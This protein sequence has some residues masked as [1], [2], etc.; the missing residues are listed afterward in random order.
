MVEEGVYA[1][2]PTAI[3]N[4]L[5]GHTVTSQNEV[6]ASHTSHGSPQRHGGSQPRLEMIYVHS[7]GSR[8]VAGKT[9]VPDRPPRCQ[10]GPM[11]HAMAQPRD[12][13]NSLL[14]M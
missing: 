9:V 1:A 4:I 10:S 8:P 7:T 12:A 5:V 11:D 3:A 13:G 6:H 2:N 14:E